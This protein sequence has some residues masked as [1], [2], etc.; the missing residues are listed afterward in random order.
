VDDLSCEVSLSND[1]PPDVEV[2]LI[3]SLCRREAAQAVARFVKMVGRPIPWGPSLNPRRGLRKATAE[4]LSP[5]VKVYLLL[6]ND[7][8]F[9]FYSD[10]SEVDE[11]Q[12]DNPTPPAT[13]WRGWLEERWYR[14][15]TAWYEADAGVALWARRTWDWLHSLTRPDE[16]L[17]VRL[18]AT[19]RIDLH[20]PASRSREAVAA[21]WNNYLSRRW[22][23][24]VTWLSFNAAIA[25]P[26]LVLLWPLP[27]PNLIGYW[28]AYRAIHHWLI[29][30]GIGAVRKQQI[31]TQFHAERG[32]DLP[33]ERDEDG[34][35]RHAV[36]DG[37]GH[38][39]DDYVSWTC[40]S[41]GANKLTNQ[42][43]TRDSTDPSDA[44]GPSGVS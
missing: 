17:L 30:R 29:V 12:G 2:S 44:P 31:P 33:V 19:R 32:L 1:H 39:L 7:E 28:F 11:S 13:G 4:Q 16:S 3:G 34:K 25:P 14:F 23:S 26:A 43:P 20:H 41:N 42:P 18:R 36:I 38:R 21:I 24:H 5:T 15:Q 37:N 22:R 8:Q 35:A 6:V 27:G 40:S 10:E 9:F